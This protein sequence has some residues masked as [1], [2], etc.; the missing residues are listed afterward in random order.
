MANTI[1]TRVVLRND[2]AA[3]W[4]AIEND[5]SKALL[6]G[7]MGIE[8]DTSLFKL[9]KMHETE[10]RLCT[11]AELEYANDVPDLSGVTNS[12]KEATT[13][14]G[15]GSGAVVG[16]VGIVKS[17]LY[18]G[19]TDYTYTAY[20]WA[21]IGVNEDGS[22]KYDWAA[23]DGNY[24]AENV[25]TSKKITLAGN[26]SSIGNYAK[27][28]EINAGTSLQTILSG[29]FQ[30]TFQPSVT[31]PTA[32]ISIASV[33][34]KEVGETYTKPTAT[35]TTTAGSY[36]YGPATG[37]T[38]DAN[39]VR[40]V[41]GSEP[42]TLGATKPTVAYKEN[43]S[44]MGAGSITLA[45]SEYAS[46]ATTEYFTDAGQ[47]YTFSGLAKHNAS[48]ASA[49]DNLGELSKPEKK[50]A[51]NLITVAAK[52]STVKGGRYCFYGVCNNTLTEDNTTKG[53]YK[54]E[55]FDIGNLSSAN[56]RSLTKSGLNGALPVTLEVPLNSTQVI[57]AA[58]ANKYKSLVAKDGNAQDGIVSFDKKTGVSVEGAISKIGDVSTGTN[59]DVW[60][61]TWTDPI[62]SAKALK[63]TWS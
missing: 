62:A 55:S 27:G 45:A 19:A 7:E 59:Y 21:K 1:N 56:V 25:Y 48:T 11:W 29:M 28:K 35:L 54:R 38:Y 17:P 37:V 6:V 50:I 34:T 36:S 22:D 43:S 32:S 52:S 15:L 46:G 9:G 30:T 39:N 40:L 16:D 3:N 8:T 5:V 41:L 33:T 24:S 14:A 31:N 18:E 61:V 51:A 26:Y 20:V 60:Y 10:D 53:H 12:V 42:G 49:N 4:K 2:T 47:T 13:L 58:P 63:L 44:S 23:M 57:F